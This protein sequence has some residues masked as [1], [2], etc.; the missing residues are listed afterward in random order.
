MGNRS[1]Y[2][3]FVQIGNGYGVV[4]GSNYMGN[5]SE[6]KYYHKEGVGSFGS[7]QKKESEWENH[8]NIQLTELFHP[9]QSHIR[10]QVSHK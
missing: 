10:L 5:G 6:D 4:L 7:G 1:I 2:V 8:E 9:L 3:E